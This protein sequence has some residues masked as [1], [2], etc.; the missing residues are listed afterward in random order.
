MPHDNKVFLDHFEELVK[1]GLPRR[2]EEY[3]GF[4]LRKLARQ[5]FYG[6]NNFASLSP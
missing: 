5:A 3:H 2:T 4:F 6:R 1:P